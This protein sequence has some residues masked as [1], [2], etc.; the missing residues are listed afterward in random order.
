MKKECNW[1][2]STRIIGPCEGPPTHKCEWGGKYIYACE[3]HAKAI[4]QAS[5]WSGYKWAKIDE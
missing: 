1:K 4:L 5:P 3:H 2:E